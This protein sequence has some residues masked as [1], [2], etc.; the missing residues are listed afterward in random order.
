MFRWF[1]TVC[2]WSI[3]TYSNESIRRGRIA[4]K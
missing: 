3:G 4:E 1:R 2:L